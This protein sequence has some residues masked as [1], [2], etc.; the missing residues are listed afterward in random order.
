M[1]ADVGRISILVLLDLSAAFDTISHPILLNRLSTHLGLTGSALSWFN[2]YL[3]DRQQFVSI[4]GSCSR[5]APVNHGVPQGSVLGPI[6]FTIYMIPLGQIIRRHGLSYHCYADDTQLYLSTS[7][8][9]T[10]PPQAIVNCLYAIRLWMT[11]NLLKLNSKKTEIMVMGPKVQL[12][13]MGDLLL[14]VDGCS[15]TPSPEVRNLGVILDSTLSFESHIKSVTKSAFFHLKNI[16]R[17]RL[18]LSES[19]AETLIHSFISSRLDY[20]NAILFGLPDTT[21]DRLQY[22]QNSA[23][24]VLTRTRRWEHITPT[25]KRLHWLPVNFR[26]SY[27]LLLLT[28]K[29]LHNQAPQY[30]TD[31]LDDYTPARNLRSAD[32]EL[33]AVPTSNRRKLG[34]R[35]FS[36][37]APTLWNSL[38]LA[39]RQLPTLDS[40]KSALKTHLFTK[41]FGPY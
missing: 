10:L 38:P 20:C 30:L 25:L 18:S 32:L 21:L 24:R 3:S 41:A 19:V 28:Y 15:I 35:A 5:P 6:L 23:A 37:S 26:I 13:R 1:A 29:A 4:N 2:S 11:T 7:P 40:F 39:I 17:L 27:K 34:D 8:N 12:Q 9:P 31:L 16:S 22:V 14:Q 33:L 36:V